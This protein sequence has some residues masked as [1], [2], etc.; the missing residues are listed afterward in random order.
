ML[1]VENGRAR[2]GHI[3]NLSNHHSQGAGKKYGTEGSLAPPKQPRPAAYLGV[4]L[5]S[6]L[7]PTLAPA[8]C[9]RLLNV[10]LTPRLKQS[11]RHQRK[12]RP[13]MIFSPLGL[14]SLSTIC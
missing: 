12:L 10:P 5:S 6:S 1:G 13:N 11:V 2:L 8:E 14:S 9:P 7:L 3:A 4:P